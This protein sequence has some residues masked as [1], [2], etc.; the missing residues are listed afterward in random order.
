M[1]IRTTVH[2]PEKGR[3]AGEELEL[4]DDEA[5]ARIAAGYAVAADEA[6]KPAEKPAAEP[7]AGPGTGPG[8]EPPA[9]Q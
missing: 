6:V 5:S 9:G 7:G 2:W 4:P 3:I 1:K 8:T